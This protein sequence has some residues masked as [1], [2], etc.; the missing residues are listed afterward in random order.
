MTYET[1]LALLLTFQPWWQ[2]YYEPAESRATR[3]QKI[4]HAQMIVGE[5]VSRRKGAFPGTDKQLV[6]LL[7]TAGWWET[8]YNSRIH[9]GNCYEDE[10]DGGRARGVYQVQKNGV[11]PDEYWEKSEGDGWEPTYYATLSAALSF[12]HAWKVCHERYGIKGVWAAY[13]RGTCTSTF[14]GHISRVR[15]YRKRLKDLG[16]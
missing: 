12:T 15:W 14:P 11:Y 1:I 3:L 2:D 9:A 8:R 5:T 6:A 7:M 13:G 16:G 4:A 10:C